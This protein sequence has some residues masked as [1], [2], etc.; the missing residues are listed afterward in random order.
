VEKETGSEVESH[1]ERWRK[2]QKRAGSRKDEKVQV[3]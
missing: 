1:K 2:H 3:R